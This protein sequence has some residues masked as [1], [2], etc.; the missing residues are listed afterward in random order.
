MPPK[1]DDK[2]KQKAT[3]VAV[4]KV[5]FSFLGHVGSVALALPLRIEVEY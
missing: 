2:N 1:K 5:S 4:D 3:K